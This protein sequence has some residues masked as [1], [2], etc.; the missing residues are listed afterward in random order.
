MKYPNG[1]GGIVKLKGKRRRP[2]CVRITVGWDLDAENKKAKQIKKPLGYFETHAAALQALLDYNKNPAAF[3]EVD[4]TFA[5]V[6]DRWS[7]LKY[8]A[9]SDSLIRSYRAAFRALAPL[10]ELVFS[11]LRLVQI[12]RAVDLSNKNLP[13]MKNIKQLVIFLYEFAINH[14]LVVSN[15]NLGQLIDIS[16]APVASKRKPAIFTRQTIN[17]LW[18]ASGSFAADVILVLLYTGLRVSELLDLKTEDINF[19]DR[20]FQVVKSKTT[21]GVRSVP[22]CSKI[23]PVMVRISGQEYFVEVSG[24]ALKYQAFLNNYFLPALEPLG[25][26]HLPHDCRHS[27]I[28]ALSGLGVDSRVV[29]SIVG[30][31][32]GIVT[33][34]IYTHFSLPLLLEAVDLLD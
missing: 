4:L 33:E 12:Q 1:F 20:F 25:V 34:D 13:T 9:A 26:D 32:S 29:R 23:L 16:A 11:S 8:R 3:E 24:S 14:D 31:K 28:S 19:G 18:A 10:H 22:I 30:H 2:Y 6:Y 27:F 7:R 15:K 5:D 21:A 17:S